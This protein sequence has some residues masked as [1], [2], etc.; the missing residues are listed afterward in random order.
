MFFS[1]SKLVKAQGNKY[2]PGTIDI[3]LTR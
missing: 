1:L 3:Y 2:T